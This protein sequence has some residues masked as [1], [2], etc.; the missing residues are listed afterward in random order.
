MIINC[1]K[2]NVTSL[3]VVCRPEDK[4]GVITVMKTQGLEF[5]QEFP[6]GENVL[7]SFE[8]P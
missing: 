1:R 7:L 2:F 8:K 6:I 5:K 3:G 4:E